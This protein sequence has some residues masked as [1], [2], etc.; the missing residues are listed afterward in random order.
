MSDTTHGETQRA[1]ATRTEFHDA[2]REAFA[3]IAQVGCREAWLCDEDFAD[4]PLNERAVIELLTHWAAAHRMSTVIARVY[5]VVVLRLPR[6]VQWRPQ[7][8]HDVQCAAS[9]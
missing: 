9:L 4:W 8:S 3:E 2:L 5:A 7:W 6:S 1:I